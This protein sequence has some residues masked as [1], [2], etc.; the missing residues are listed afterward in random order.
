MATILPDPFLAT[1]FTPDVRWHQ[2]TLDACA[3]HGIDA[4]YPEERHG[5]ISATPRR[6][7]EFAAG[8]HCARM[9]LRALCGTAGPIPARPDR[10]P[11]WPSGIVGSISHDAALCIAGVARNSRL[12]ALGIDVELVTQFG[13][14]DE[15]VVCTSRERNILLGSLRGEERARRLALVFCAKEATYKA[16]YALTGAWLEFADVEIALPGSRPGSAPGN[17]EA[18]LRRAV[19]PFPAGRILD[20]RCGISG[21][22][23]AATLGLP[24]GAQRQLS[25]MDTAGSRS[26]CGTVT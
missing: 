25:Q 22:R 2:V 1:L 13:E 11:L 16:Q 21:M 15:W 8:R 14:D 20:G 23:A 9:A 19:G 24:A 6:R 26:P 3:D 10:M 5:I 17:F 18:H 12:A 7:R 4:L